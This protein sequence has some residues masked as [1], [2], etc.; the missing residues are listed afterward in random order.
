M[1]LG[2]EEFV[3]TVKEGAHISDQEAERVS[4]ATLKTLA[5]RLSSGETE[6]LA[7]RLPEQ[8][9]SCLVPDLD[10]A[11]R[12]HVDEFLHRIAARTGIDDASAERDARAVFVALKQAVGPEEFADMRSE[13][14]ADFDPLLDQAARPAPIRPD[15]LRPPL[16]TIDA[17]LD[18]LGQQTGLDRDRALRAAEAVLEVLAIRISGGQIED[19]EPLLPP[20]LRP[21]LERGRS[22]SGE[23]AVPLSV[24]AFLQEIAQREDV[25]R[26]LA[27]E[28]ARAVLTVL[29]EVLPEPE[30]LDIKQQLPGEY[31]VLLKR[32]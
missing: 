22:V 30:F 25:D 9:R 6:D 8:L 32:G 5:D 3:T 2:Y 1:T 17:L 18:R 20:E 10:T 23:R 7:E 11:R 27:A 15:G 13:L 14:P 31:S 16:V 28:H 4:C 19:I 12:F 24:D 26:G 29:R 21:A